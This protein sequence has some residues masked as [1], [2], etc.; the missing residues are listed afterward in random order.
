[1]I[2][3]PIVQRLMRRI[4]DMSQSDEFD[5]SEESDFTS[6][7]NDMVASPNNEQCMGPP[8]DDSEDG[9]HNPNAPE[10]DEQVDR[11]SSSSDFTSH[12]G[13]FTATLD[14]RNFS[15]NE[16]GL[17]GQRRFSRKKKD[18]LKDA[19]YRDLDLNLSLNRQEICR[20]SSNIFWPLDDVE[21]TNM[22]TAEKE[23]EPTDS[24][25]EVILDL[26]PPWKPIVWSDLLDTARTMLPSK[27]WNNLSPDL[28]ASFWGL[29]LYDLY[30]PR[31]RYESEIAK[32]HS[33]LKALEELSDNSNSAITKRKKDKERIQESLDRLTSELQKHEENVAS[34][35][36]RLAREKDKWLSSCPDT[37]KINMEFLQRCIFPR[38]TFSMPDAVYCAM[39]VHTLHSLG[40]PF[41]N[42]VNHIDVLICKTLQPMICCCTEYE[43]G[44]LGRF[45]YE[46]MKIAYYWKSD[47]SIY[48]RECGNMPGFAVYYRY[49]NSRRVTYGQ[50][51]KVHWKWSQRITRLLIQCLES[52]EYMEIRNALI[53]LTKISSVFPVTRKSGINLEKQIAKIKS[54]ERED[55]KVLATGVAAA[56]T[57]R[58]PSWVTDEE[59]GMGYLELK[60]TPS[61]ASK[62]LAGSLVAIPN[63]SGLNIFQN[64]SSG[65][66]TVASGTQHLDAGNSVKEQL[67][68]L[69]RLVSMIHS[70]GN[71]FTE[72]PGSSA[73]VPLEKKPVDY[74]QDG[75]LDDEKGVS[76]IEQDALM[77][78]SNGNLLVESCRKNLSTCSRYLMI[79][80]DVHEQSGEQEPQNPIVELSHAE[81]APAV[82]VEVNPSFENYKCVIDTPLMH[83][84]KLNGEVTSMEFGSS[85]RMVEYQHMEETEYKSPVKNQAVITKAQCGDSID[86]S[87]QVAS[88]LQNNWLSCMHVVNEPSGEQAQ[89]IKCCTSEADQISNNENQKLQTEDSISSESSQKYDR[90]V[91]DVGP[92]I[93]GYNGSELE[94]SDG[95]SQLKYIVQGGEEGSRIDSTTKKLNEGDAGGHSIDSDLL[96]ERCRSNISSAVQNLYVV[97]SDLTNEQSGEQGTSSNE[98][99]EENVSESSD[100]VV[101][102]QSHLQESVSEIPTTV[103]QLPLGILDG[104][105]VGKMAKNLN[106]GE[107]LPDSGDFKSL[108]EG[109]E[110]PTDTQFRPGIELNSQAISLESDSPVKIRALITMKKGNSKGMYSREADESSLENEKIAQNAGNIAIQKTFLI[111]EYF[112]NELGLSIPN[113]TPSGNL[114]NSV[115]KAA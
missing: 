115:S 83:E 43:A 16:D 100:Y 9:D 69:F 98:S 39:F 74:G 4:R 19:A 13:D 44:R 93:C 26:G 8:S 88:V 48:E 28:Y 94:S 79:A 33:A 27:A 15:D 52:T 99:W 108:L 101:P 75:K 62:S 22:S 17:D 2:T 104:F 63:G 89:L 109:H 7:S 24:S 72:N 85:L 92:K 71:S 45:L 3:T 66:R 105:D 114:S 78:C 29:T 41:F 59:F 68:L 65:G 21:S 14:R 91:T 73:K 64:E 32:Q 23:S 18:T 53:M 80:D 11:E 47:E 57:V 90:C 77:P 37:L 46:T 40:T 106:A 6:A 1:M 42:T 107:I 67:P 84:V 86:G 34:V 110:Y 61:L 55:L 50:F 12:S 25:G 103:V 51:I 56:L 60:P 112:G 82:S 49:P 95:P 54:D 31:H 20:S 111:T 35:R 70:G 76:I 58:K 36:R 102:E 81:D 5:E 87:N 30:V 38:C 113:S 10:I 96:V 97:G